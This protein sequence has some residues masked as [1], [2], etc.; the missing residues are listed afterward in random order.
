MKSKWSTFSLFMLG[1]FL[2]PKGLVHNEPNVTLFIEADETTATAAMEKAATEFTQG[3]GV[4]VAVEKFSY[5]LSMK[6]AVEDLTA[7][8]GHYDLVVQ[9]ADGLVKFA[10]DG[11]IYSM[12]DLERQTGKKADFESDLYPGAWQNLSVFK[13]TRYG[14]PLAANSMVLIYRKDLLDNPAE[15]RAFRARYGYELSAPGDWKQYKQVAEFFNRPDRGLYGT[16]IQGKRHPA[17]WFEWLNFAFSFGGG[18][19]D[20]QRSWEYGPIVINS[21]ETIRGTE[22]YNSLKQY[23]PPGFTNFTWDD[24]GEQMREGHV[25]M[26]ILWSDAMHSVEDPKRSTV[27]GK[28]G[29]A[30]LPVGAGGPTA[31]IAGATYFVSRYAKHPKEAFQFELWMMRKDCQIK[32]ELLGGSSARKSVYSDEQVR[33][34]PYEGAISQN[35]SV[36]RAMIDT[37]PETPAISEI[38]ET[39]ISDVIADKKTAKESLDDAAAAINKAT[40]NK[41]VL[42]FPRF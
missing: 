1:L 12:D 6:K 16:L 36:G 31:Q 5:A 42:K 22:F 40:S 7:K 19:M 3:T 18:V 35:L 25:F 23:S 34:L 27:A 21:P 28:V 30:P 13:G 9:N 15:K 32:Q 24:A 10:T 20:R 26:C 33:A 41:A 17:I 38:I 11:S 37:V 39:A 14:Y 8:T 4:G 2:Q 29:F